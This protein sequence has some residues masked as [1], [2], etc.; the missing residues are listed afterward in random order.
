MSNAIITIADLLHILFGILILSSLIAL[1]S[2]LIVA[3]TSLALQESIMTLIS[4]Q[5]IYFWALVLSPPSRLFVN[6]WLLIIASWKVFFL[7]SRREL[8]SVGTKR[9]FHH[10]L[11]SIILNSVSTRRMQLIYSEVGRISLFIT[12]QGFF[13]MVQSYL[14]I[15]APLISW[16][17]NFQETSIF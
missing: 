3:L 5:S 4:V 12:K 11:K 9:L 1:H 17:E 14:L 13:G 2:F 7:L 8:G 10:F 15:P 6:I 16:P